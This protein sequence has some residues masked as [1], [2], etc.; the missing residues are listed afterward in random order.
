MII[1]STPKNRMNLIC[2]CGFTRVVDYIRLDSEALVDSN[3]NQKCNLS[4]YS[5]GY[6]GRNKRMMT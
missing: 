4:N 3:Q 2:V 5:P 1:I 6:S